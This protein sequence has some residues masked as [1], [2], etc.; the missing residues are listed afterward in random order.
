[1]KPRRHTIWTPLVPLV[2]LGPLVP[3]SSSELGFL[4]AD[5]GSVQ[6]ILSPLAE[7]CMPIVNYQ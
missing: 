3:I 5:Q 1:M 7:A 6:Q 4:G 2:P